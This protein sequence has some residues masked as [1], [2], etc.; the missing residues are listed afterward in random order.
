[1]EK[2]NFEKKNSVLPDFLLKPVELTNAY[3]VFCKQN[4]ELFDSYEQSIK[5]E[6]NKSDIF[7]L[8]VEKIVRFEYSDG[9][10]FE[11]FNRNILYKKNDKYFLADLPS[12]ISQ[13]KKYPFLCCISQ[14]D[15]IGFFN[16]VYRRTKIF[17]WK[18]YYDD[19]S[20]DD[21]NEWELRVD[22]SNQ[23]Y[24]SRAGHMAWPKSFTKDIMIIR[25]NFKILKAKGKNL[26]SDE[27]MKAYM[28]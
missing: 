25:T 2:T 20:I 4:P 19:E 24:F 3:D 14:E 16:C 15:A 23:K 21:G 11:G 9:D 17:D 12:R 28:D 26:L 10:F 6:L 8:D 5:E 13:N 1:M 7:E 22:F 27:I 18:R